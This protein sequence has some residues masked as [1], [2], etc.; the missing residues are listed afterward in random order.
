MAYLKYLDVHGLEIFHFDFKK[1][2]IHS[3]RHIRVRISSYIKELR[4]NYTAF[5][6][7]R[8]HYIIVSR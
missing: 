2:L 3:L 6:F 7:H 5:T 1:K 4:K 8:T